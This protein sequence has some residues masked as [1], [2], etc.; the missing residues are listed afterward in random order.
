MPLLAVSAARS[1]FDNP[2]QQGDKLL[3][4]S[5]DLNRFFVRP[6]MLNDV[7]FAPASTRLEPKNTRGNLR[8]TATCRSNVEQPLRNPG[9]CPDGAGIEFLSIV[10]L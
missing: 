1:K 7:F 4:S 5:I 3:E 8:S 10:I 6:A 9:I 2:L